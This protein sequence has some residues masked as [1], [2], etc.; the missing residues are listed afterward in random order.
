MVIKFSCI[1][2]KRNETW[3]AAKLHVFGNERLFLEQRCT[4]NWNIWLV[5]EALMHYKHGSPQY[6][7]Q[8]FRVV[9]K[10]IVRKLRSIISLGF[11]SVVYPYLYHCTTVT[12]RY[13]PVS[14]ASLREKPCRRMD[15][16]SSRHGP[17]RNTS[18]LGTGTDPSTVKTCCHLT[19]NFLTTFSSDGKWRQILVS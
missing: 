15:A 6:Q 19:K 8:K 11:D 18:S 14:C 5:M 9:L 1:F 16:L 2:H 12:E 13:R 7:T 17:L 3:L 10:I 4:A